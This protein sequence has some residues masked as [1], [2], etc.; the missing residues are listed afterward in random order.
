MEKDLAN[1]LTLIL[2]AFKDTFATLITLNQI[3]STFD[4]CIF[5]LISIKKTI[6]SRYFA[7]NILL[8]FDLTLIEDVSVSSI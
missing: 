8:K 5:L 6:I 1:S 7:I 3:L 4:P 2:L